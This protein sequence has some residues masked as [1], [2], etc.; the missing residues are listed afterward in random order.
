MRQC[1]SKIKANPAFP[2]NWL[3]SIL[4]FSNWLESIFD[5]DKNRLNS[6]FFQNSLICQT[7]VHYWKKTLRVL[8]LRVFS[9]IHAEGFQNAHKS[10]S[11]LRAKDS[12]RWLI[13]FKIRI[14]V[15][16]FEDTSARNFI[17][18][19]FWSIRKLHLKSVSLLNLTIATIF[20]LLKRQCDEEM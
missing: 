5:I 1:F 16:F 11:N 10:E 14:C 8:T 7:N 6:I 9:Y 3:V 18:K 2:T 19:W 12:V 20:I 15:H 13:G 17:S 4:I